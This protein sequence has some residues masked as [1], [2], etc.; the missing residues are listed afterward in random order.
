MRTRQLVGKETLFV[1]NHSL[2]ALL[3]QKG[4]MLDIG[5]QQALKHRQQVQSPLT[6]RYL[7]HLN[8]NSPMSH[9][10]GTCFKIE[11]EA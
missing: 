10:C 8:F 1:L 11:T 6:V 4:E 2:P 5:A 9:V 7:P 3:L